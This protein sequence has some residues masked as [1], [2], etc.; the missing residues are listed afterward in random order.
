VRDRIGWT[1]ALA[2]TVRNQSGNPLVNIT[3]GYGNQIGQNK[4]TDNNGEYELYYLPAGTYSIKAWAP[5]FLSNPFEILVS[6]P[7]TTV[8]VDFVMRPATKFL[9]LPIG[10]R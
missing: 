5:G 10:K 9:Y 4:V 7:P 3:V 1:Y 2:G 8:G 6:V